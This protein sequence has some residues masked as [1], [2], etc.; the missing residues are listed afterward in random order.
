MTVAEMK[1]AQIYLGNFRLVPYTK[2][3]YVND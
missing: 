1:D 2:K 3:N